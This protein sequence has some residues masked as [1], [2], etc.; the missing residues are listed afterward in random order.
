MQRAL[1]A[2]LAMCALPRC[3]GKGGHGGGGGQCE[4]DPETGE[5]EP[6]FA[7]T[8]DACRLVDTRWI[9]RRSEWDLLPRRPSPSLPRTIAPC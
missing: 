4:I 7:R 9:Q 2:A 6:C 5:C 1:T 8:V 3:W